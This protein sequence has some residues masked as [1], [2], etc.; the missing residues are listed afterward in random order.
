[1]G[2]KLKKDYEAHAEL[3]KALSDVHRLQILEMLCR[4]N[5]VLAKSLKNSIL[6][7]LHFHTT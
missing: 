1:M 7:S 6:H 4:G 2:K 3:F 5:F